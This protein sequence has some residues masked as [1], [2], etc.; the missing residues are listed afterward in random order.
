MAIIECTGEAP[1]K[2]TVTVECNGTG[3]VFSNTELIE[4]ERQPNNITGL[5][6]VPQYQQCN[7]SVVF[8][9][10]AGSSE[11]FIRTFNTTPL[12]PLDISS[13]LSTV[14]VTPTIGAGSD[15]PTMMTGAIIGIAVG[16]FIFVVVILVLI[17][18]LVA[19]FKYIYRDKLRTQCQ[20]QR[21]DSE[22]DH[23]QEN[24]DDSEQKGNGKRQ[25][26]VKG[27]KY[28]LVEQQP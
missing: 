24:A 22:M 25:K 11:P 16:C 21:H 7:I 19:V 28:N 8:S 6:S 2:V 26:K 3:V 17:V 13:S 10:E 12:L 5:I 4:Q 9:N 20:R 15:S 23:L 27:D 18:V 14:S 1:E